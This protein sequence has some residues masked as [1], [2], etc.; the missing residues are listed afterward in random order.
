MP[1]TSDRLILKVL[2]ELNSSEVQES[3]Q[4]LGYLLEFLENKEDPDPIEMQIVEASYQTIEKLRLLEGF[5][6]KYVKESD[7]ILKGSKLQKLYDDKLDPNV[8]F[9]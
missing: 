4:S 5:L 1:K 8:L 6:K 9:N 2:R 7:K 3:F